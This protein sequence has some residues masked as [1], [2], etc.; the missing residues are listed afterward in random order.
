MGMRRDYNSKKGSVKNCKA[1]LHDFGGMA[2]VAVE[3]P[4]NVAVDLVDAAAKNKANTVSLQFGGHTFDVRVTSARMNTYDPKTGV[5]VSEIDE[6]GDCSL[7][8]ITW[9]KGP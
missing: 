9:V 1:E 7:S 4:Y 2:K 3:I 8:Q 6:P 5:Q